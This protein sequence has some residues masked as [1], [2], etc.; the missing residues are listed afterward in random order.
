MLREEDEGEEGESNGEDDGAMEP[1]LAEA[2]RD[3]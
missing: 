3:A 1:I 2:G